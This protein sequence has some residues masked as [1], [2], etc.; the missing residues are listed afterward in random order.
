[1]K[2]EWKEC[3]LSDVIELTID[4]RGKTPKKLGGDWSN[5]STPYKALSAKNIKT[6]QVVQPETIRYVDERLYRLWMRDEILPG[7][8]LVTSEAP[9]GQLYLWKTN[10]K[11]VLSQRLFGLR[12]K[13]EVNPC[14]VYYYMITPKFQGELHARATGTTVEGLRQPELLKCKLYLPSLVTQRKIAA[15][16]S[17]LDDKIET[18]N[19]ICRNLEETLKVVFNERFLQNGDSEFEDEVPLEKLCIC[20][21]KGT[22]PTTLGMPFAPTGINFVKVESITDTH[23]FDCSK[24]AYVDEETHL[25]LARSQLAENDI[26]FTIAGTLG[27]YALVDSDILPANTNQAVSII[28]ADSRR[29]CPEYLYCFFIGDWHHAYYTKRIQQAVQANL[30]LGTIR[31]LPIPILQKKT[32]SQYLSVIVPVVRQIKSLEKENRR[33]AALRDTLLPRLMSGKLDVSAVNL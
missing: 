15:V 31:S 30:S 8:I 32:M 3:A 28:R 11:I 23:T 27:R 16:L 1:M 26:V 6:G 19:A 10:E 29:V 14:Y 2:S 7:D 25:A 20:V 18:N 17:S 21:T 5:V 9:F 24:F 33:L 22:T 13:Q 12:V 4:H